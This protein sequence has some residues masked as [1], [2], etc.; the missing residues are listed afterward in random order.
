MTR[1]S[2]KINGK[3]VGTSLQVYV[4][5]EISGN[6]NPCYHDGNGAIRAFNIPADK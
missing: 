1:N 3:G 4:V 6:N 2:I 5:A